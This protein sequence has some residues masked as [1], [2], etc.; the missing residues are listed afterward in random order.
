ML[1]LYQYFFM[2][3]KWKLAQLIEAS[4]C[5]AMQVATSLIKIL[6]YSKGQV[7]QVPVLLS[8]LILRYRSWILFFF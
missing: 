3:P 1:T 5:F 8:I 7:C 4:Y 2:D 6:H